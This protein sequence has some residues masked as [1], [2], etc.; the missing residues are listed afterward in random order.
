MSERFHVPELA[1]RDEVEL[2]GPEAH[3]LANVLR[4]KPGD[5]VLLFDGHGLECRAAVVAIQGKRVRLQIL[6]RE[7]VQ[8]ELPWAIVIHAA[9]PKGDRQ[10]WLVEKC[11]ELGVARLVPLRT[12]RGV[13]QPD[14]GALERLRRYV[15]EASKQCGR[16]VLMEIGSPA[17]WPSEPPAGRAGWA[18]VAHPSGRPWPEFLHELSAAEKS[19]IALPGEIAL[20]IG[21][22]GG[23]TD[24]EVEQA[25]ASGWQTLS[26]GPRILRV[27]TAAAFCVALA[28][29][30]AELR[31]GDSSEKKP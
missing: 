25:V 24:A 7:E 2:I 26:L 6:S 11:V 14:E 20:A 28:S 27:E 4:A 29:V 3:H 22:E 12:Q 10:R 5:E 19:R 17:K 8:R 15:L 31:T 16:T 21:P 30:L 18:W 1:G 13:A 23:F 9:L